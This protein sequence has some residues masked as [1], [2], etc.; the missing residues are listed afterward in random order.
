MAVAVAMT[1]V[2]AVISMILI[3][4]TAQRVDFT[5]RT[6]VNRAKAAAALRFCGRGEHIQREADVF[7]VSAGVPGNG[8]IGAGFR[9]ASAQ[10]VDHHIHGT[11]Q[12]YDGEQTDGNI[13]RHRGTHGCVA[14]GYAA[15][16]AVAAIV[17]VMAGIAAG[18]RIPQV[19]L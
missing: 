1:S 10:R 2:I 4:A 9:H 7:E 8:G 14:I 19:R 18:G 17:V 5:V 6:A 13:D 12:F 16:A 11:E 15:T 3:A